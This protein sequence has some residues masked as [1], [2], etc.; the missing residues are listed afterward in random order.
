M[1]GLG[2][3]PRQNAFCVSRSTNP[4]RP[5]LSAGRSLVD[6]GLRGKPW[7]RSPRSMTR[8]STSSPSVLRVDL[9]PDH[10]PPDAQSIVEPD[11]LSV[12]E[13]ASLSVAAGG[14]LDSR[15]GVCGGAQQAPRLRP[16]FGFMPAW[17]HPSGQAR[18]V[19]VPICRPMSRHFARTLL[20]SD[21][22]DVCSDR[23]S[24]MA[25]RGVGVHSRGIEE[26][27]ICTCWSTAAS[28]QAQ[29]VSVSDAGVHSSLRINCGV[30]CAASPAS[31]IR[32]WR[33]RSATT[34]LNVVHEPPLHLHSD[35]CRQTGR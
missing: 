14:C 13:F 32:P 25:S 7:R 12:V 23:R 17:R 35:L 2:Q 29:I 6:D 31:R 3:P 27:W 18:D 26:S 22:S 15:A 20:F 34:A 30:M 28:F 10:G 11:L 9:E 33:Q 24:I 8:A 21:T 19:R 16:G 4:V 5:L 1:S